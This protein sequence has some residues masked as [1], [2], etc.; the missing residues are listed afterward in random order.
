M[1]TNSLSNLYFF[2]IIPKERVECWGQ[3]IRV[4]AF[5]SAGAWG[6]A[7]HKLTYWELAAIQP[8]QLLGMACR[9]SAICCINVFTIS[10]IAVYYGISETI[11]RRRFVHAALWQDLDFIRL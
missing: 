5:G 8:C 4:R 11:D 10:L 9:A 1:S 7:K 2:D 6:S 3:P